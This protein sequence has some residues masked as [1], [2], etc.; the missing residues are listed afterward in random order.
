M[1]NFLL[2]AVLISMVQTDFQYELDK[3]LWTF[4]CTPECTFN[5]SEITSATAQFFPTNC[6]EICGILVLNSNTDL[7]HSQLQVLFSNMTQLS[8]A[9]RVENTS[10]TNLSFFN[11]GRVNRVT[12]YFCKAYGIS[13]VNNSQLTDVSSLRYFN[14]NTD[15]YT[16]ECPVRV[17]NNKQLDAEKL[18]CDRNPFRAWFTLKISG[19]LKDCECSGGRVIGYLLRDAKVCGAVSNLNLTNVA[20]T[21]YQLI[22][23]GNTIHVRGDF[24][25]QRTNLTNLAFFPILESVISIN[26]PR[27]QKILMNIHDNPNM[28]TLGLPKLNFLYDNLA[29]GQFVANF[30]N[31]H[32][33]F[34][35]TY[36]EMFL[37]MH[38]NVYFKNLHATYCE[39]EK[40]Q[41]VETL[42]EKYE[43]CWLTTTTTLKTLK[44]NCTVIS[45][46]L[47][48]ESGDE[49]YVSKLE[50]LKYLF[51]SILIHNTG[52][53]KN[54]YSPNLSCIAVMNDEPA[55]KIVSN[56]NLTYAFLPKIEN[57]ITKHQRTV[58]VHNNPQLSSEFYFLY[59]MSYRSNAKFVGDHFENGEPRRI[60]SFFIMV[61]Y[62]VLIFL[63]NN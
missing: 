17:E 40:E 63:W 36:G 30:E 14:L 24:E 22:P 6:S 18:I 27:N 3:I 5:H 47:K 60:L 62:S 12:E 57:I 54:R 31:L 26:G 20:D 34:C 8:G 29:G 16:K 51:G 44:S 23:L 11:E 41:F 61:V 53:S 42:L 50:S 19:N 37:F 25:I 58:V 10:F 13:I 52:F 4:R 59:P 1:R 43:I 32:P 35:V 49:E 56:L 46:D 28:T 39:G 21:S 9:L 48:I 45:G 33:D 2:V 7:S 55:I 38:Q 15:E